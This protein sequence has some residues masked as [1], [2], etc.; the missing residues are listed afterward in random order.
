MTKR[1]SM[2]LDLEL[3]ADAK[4]VLGTHEMTETVHAA[5]REVVRQQR[6]RR[7][8]ARLFDSADEDWLRRPVTD[9]RPAPIRSSG[10][11]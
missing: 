9:V 5:L 3:L 6:L 1:T 7:L 8:V 11:R 10:A 2:N 4:E